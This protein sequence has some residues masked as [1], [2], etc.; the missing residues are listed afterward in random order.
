MSDHTNHRSRRTTAAA[1]VKIPDQVGGG[2]Q[3]AERWDRLPIPGESKCESVRTVVIPRKRTKNNLQPNLQP[4]VDFDSLVALPDIFAKDT[5]DMRNAKEVLKSLNELDG[6]IGAALVDGDSGMMLAAD[7]ST[8]FNFEI[9]AAGNTE[10][11]RAK[12]KVEKALGL[13]DVIEDVLITLGKQYHL[14]RPVANKPSLFFYM[15]LDRSKA[16]LAMARY[17]LSDVEKDLS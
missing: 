9:A 17:K 10:V 8:S 7:S 11:L 13:N 14:I 5:S 12:R 1:I 4:A 2:R 3:H 6:Y 16:N 15:V